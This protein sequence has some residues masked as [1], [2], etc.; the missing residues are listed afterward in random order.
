MSATTLPVRRA[1]PPVRHLAT[2]LGVLIVGAVL[3]VAIIA[4][5]IAPHDP[6]V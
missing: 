5:Y 1:L 2:G 4:P 3:L 6:F